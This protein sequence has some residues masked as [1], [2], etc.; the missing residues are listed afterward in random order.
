MWDLRET[1]WHWVGFRIANLSEKWPILTY[2]QV[3]H[4]RTIRGINITAGLD[5][6]FGPGITRFEPGTNI[7]HNDRMFAALVSLFKQIS[8]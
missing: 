1:E 2:H 8:G 4:N 6:T 3:W 5:V 7:G